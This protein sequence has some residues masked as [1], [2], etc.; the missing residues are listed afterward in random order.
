[1]AG[2]QLIISDAYL[3]LVEAVAELFPEAQWQRCVVHFYRNVFSH[4]PRSATWRMLKAIGNTPEL[5]AQQIRAE[6]EI[7]KSVVEAQKLKPKWSNARCCRSGDGAIVLQ[8]RREPF[9]MVRELNPQ[10]TNADSRLR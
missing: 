10:W 8:A 1:V 5:F 6:Y 2:V 4:V 3:G 9:S 7:C